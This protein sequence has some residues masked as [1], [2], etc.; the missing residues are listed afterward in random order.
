MNWAGETSEGQLY[1]TYV[2]YRSFKVPPPIK[3]SGVEKN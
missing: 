2:V 3:K 1:M